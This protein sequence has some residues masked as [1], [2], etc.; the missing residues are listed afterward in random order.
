M[1]RLFWKRRKT[2]HREISSDGLPKF[3]TRLWTDGSSE[4]IK[5]SVHRLM[6]RHAELGPVV[7]RR[8]F[9][10]RY[11]PVAA[12]KNAVAPS[13]RALLLAGVPDVCAGVIFVSWNKV[14]RHLEETIERFTLGAHQVELVTTVESMEV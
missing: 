13:G 12:P 14:E 7:Q 3:S 2:A 5:S 8:V 6:V 4:H 1:V 9:G 11:D 10:R